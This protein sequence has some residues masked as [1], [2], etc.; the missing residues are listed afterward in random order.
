MRVPATVFCL[1]CAAALG[2][3]LGT[4][5]DRVLSIESTGT[6]EGI[7]FFDRDGDGEVSLG[8][9]P[10]AGVEVG[11]ASVRSSVALFSA[12][13][14]ADGIFIL[15]SVD[16]ATY[17]VVVDS[18]TVGDTLEVALTDPAAFT[19]TPSDT[20]GITVGVS[21]PKLSIAAAR[22]LPEGEVIFVEGIA[23]NDRGTFGDSSVHIVDASAAIR[24]THVKPSTVLAGDSVRFLGTRAIQD[25]QPTLDDATP[26]LIDMLEVPSAETVSTASATTADGGRLDAALVELVDVTVN[27]T[28]TVSDGFRMS[29]DDGSGAAVI[30]LDEDAPIDSPEQY[31]PGT[32]IDAVGL[33]V[34][35]GAGGWLMKPR[36]DAD[37]TIK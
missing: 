24:V 17:E 34:P 26:F 19:L 33:L 2:G 30:L 15:E 35:D 25:G 22:A 11:L 12:T 3:C 27:D 28:A 7:V 16:V 10:Y 6:V 1:L 29:V 37:L 20:A 14:D 32:T 21:Y 13:S 23:L 4:G 8:D 9:T 5:E 31:V 36:S 18:E